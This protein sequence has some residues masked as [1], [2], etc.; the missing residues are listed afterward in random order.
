[1]TDV[2]DPAS[3]RD[4]EDRA[5]MRRA[6]ALAERG[7]GQTAPNPM[8]GAVVVGGGVA[9]G[10]GFHAK[11]GEAHA[12]VA[13][14]A[15]AGDRARGATVYVTLEPCNHHGKTPPCVDALIAAG[16]RRVVAAVR[17]PGRESGGGAERMRAAGIEVD[18]GAGAAE[19]REL[20][21]PFFFAE[22]GA[23][24]PWVTLKL[25]MSLDGAIAAAPGAAGSPR[26]LTGEAARK[27]VHRLR[28]QSDAIAVGI[29]TALADDPLLTVRS[30]RRPRVAP[31]RVVF[32]RAARLPLGTRLVKTAKRVPT[33]VLADEA[34]TPAA[35][36]LEAKGV[37]V[38]CATG[39]L[40]QL[41][42]LRRRG[43]R[44]LLVEGG[45]ALAGALLAAKA[46]DRLVIFQAPILL[47]A[48]ALPALGG[49]SEIKRLKVIERRE[50]GADLMTVF[51]MNSNDE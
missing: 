44:S 1:M 3:A 26:W 43:V 6:L 10:K 49:V 32:D 51:S 23:T 29:G 41:E 4:R 15:D 19:A 13:A 14:L 9:V 5:W 37:Q 11:F 42:V 18:L 27:H 21:A 46:V 39:L 36:G 2:K 30:G 25:A 50:F 24:R 16:V 33:L 47:G 34:G 40:P 17:D 20:N 35:R 7:W 8:V 12:E 28:A 31:L 22:S 48:G 38:D 45:A